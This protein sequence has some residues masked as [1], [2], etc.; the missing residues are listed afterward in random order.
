MALPMEENQETS[1]GPSNVVP[2]QPSAATNEPPAPQQDASAPAKG[3][4]APPAKKKAKKV[5]DWGKVNQLLEH[6]ALI[7]GTDTVWDG[8]NH[9][10]IKVAAMRLA[11]GNDEVRF[12]LQH[13]DRRTILPEDL[14]FEPGQD[15]AGKV[16]MF[17][18]LDLVPQPCD[19]KEVE[20]ML[21][22]LRHLCSTSAEL[23]DE[24]DEVIHWILRWQALPLQ[25]L[26]AKMDTAV[27]MHGPQGTGK[28]LYWDAW[29]DLFGAYGVT[30]SQTEIED[31]FNGWISCKLAIVGDEVVSRQEMYHNKNRLKM[32]V[33]TRDKFPIRG[34]MM[35]TRWESNH[36][37]VVFTSNESQPLALEDRDRRYMVV[38]TPTEDD[39]GLYGRVRAFLDDNGLAKW[40]WYL[41]HYPLGDFTEHTKAI[42]T[43]AKAKLI[44]L[45]LKPAQRFMSE[46]LGGYLSLPIRVCSSEQLYR[47]F[48][49]WASHAGERYPPPRNNFTRDA[50]RYVLEQVERDGNGQ[51]L[52]PALVYKVI[53][54]AKP[55]CARKAVRCWVPRGCAPPNGVTEG[56]WAA[57]SV[58]TFEGVLSSFMRSSSD[59]DEG[60]S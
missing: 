57:D 59:S 48:V 30:V 36:A 51:R 42:M 24:V 32:V 40:L 31:K 33:T 14:V 21:A 5:A 1:P 52:Q 46:W 13:R 6:V 22:L 19:E 27:V 43:T 2:L 29:R 11:Y 41:Q 45:G 26:G 7:Y 25:R 9:R 20:P 54:L 56:E 60:R 38:Y 17:R 10:I 50:E 8:V 55:G 23:A 53:S 15:I 47:A 16:N 49:R 44:E 12:W 58:D 28:N 37:N 39:T 34:M 35:E 4:G 18:G 3:E